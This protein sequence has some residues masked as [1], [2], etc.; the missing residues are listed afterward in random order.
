MSGKDSAKLAT[1]PNAGARARARDPLTKLTE[2]EKKFCLNYVKQG[3][4]NAAG[5][6]ESAGSR[7]NYNA[8]CVAASKLLR[9]A[10]VS[11]E[12]RRLT[13]KADKAAANR[14]NYELMR[15]AERKIR[16]SEIGRARAGDL[17]GIAMQDGALVFNDDV[18]RSAVKAEAQVVL[19]PDP[20]HDGNGPPPKIPATVVKLTLHDPIE[21]I[22]E[23]NKMDGVYKETN[24]QP[25]E[26]H[27]HGDV[28]AELDAQTAAQLE[29]P[30]L[31][32]AIPGS[33]ADG[34]RF[35]KTADKDPFALLAK[36]GGGKAE[37]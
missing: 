10:K 24:A 36:K 4:C 14:E 22:K 37:A 17:R 18:C 16:L 3:C 6:L 32:V 1:K 2:L 15:V 9:L 30:T 11:A 19:I 23:L 12:I 7:A 31:R 25:V 35:R 5:A 27:F 8:R 13:A 20:N 21:A 28:A 33:K 34:Q 29:D 26:I